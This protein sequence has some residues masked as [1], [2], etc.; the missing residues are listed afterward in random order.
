MT[1]EPTGNGAPNPFPRRLKPESFPNPPAQGSSKPPLTLENVRHLLV[2]NG[3]EVGYDV[4]KKR[5]GI[6]RADGELE[7]SDLV[8]LA[9]LNGLG[10]YGFLDFVNTLARRNPTNPVAEWIQSRPW[11]GQDRLQPLYATVHLTE[12]YP[13]RVRDFL[14][15]RW[16]L[17]CVAAALQ[18]SGFKARGVLNFQGP[19]GGGKTS[20]IARLVPKPLSAEW[21]KLDH[22]LDAHNKDSIFGA[23]THWICEIGELDSSFRKDVARIKGLLTN[24]CDKLRLPYARSPV[25]MP[26]RTVFAGTVNDW[27][28]L[29]DHTGN[30]R[31]WTISTTKLDFNHDI[32]MQQVFAQLEVDYRGGAQWWLTSDEEAQLEALNSRHK[33]VSVIEERVRERIAPE[34]AKRRYM[35]ASKVLEE[36][37]IRY[38]SN[39]QCRECGTVLRSIYGEPKRVNGTMKWKVGLTPDGVW[40]RHPDDDPSDEEIF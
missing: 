30:S 22:H 31:W 29:I 2:E 39:A 40:N 24:D 4:I 27:H 8:S 6:R 18:P 15:Y 3:I 35:T 37:G 1:C 38:P 19:Q 34:P 14:L 13:A 20:W 16:L 10:A 9:N 7:E 25:E 11:D 23:V 33:A 12:D 5:L 36:I 17:S 32:E 26:R 28:F 21:V